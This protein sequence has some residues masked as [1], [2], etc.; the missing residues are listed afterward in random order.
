[1]LRITSLKN[2]HLGPRVGGNQGF[3]GF[4]QAEE[5]AWDHG[6]EVEEAKRNAR[7]GRANAGVRWVTVEAGQTRKVLNSV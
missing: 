1:V 4:I 6:T 3:A 7:G 2:L 5:V